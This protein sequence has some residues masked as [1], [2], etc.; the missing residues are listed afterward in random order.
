MHLQRVINWV[1]QSQMLGLQLSPAN[2]FSVQVVSQ[3][4]LALGQSNKRPIF[5]CQAIKAFKSELFG[6]WHHHFLSFLLGGRINGQLLKSS[7]KWQGK[8]VVVFV[9]IPKKAKHFF[10]SNH[11]ANSPNMNEAFNSRYLALW[12][13]LL[14]ILGGVEFVVCWWLLQVN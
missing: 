4:I 7:N 11:E 1:Q 13:L 6:V 8:M 5:K 12:I 2:W 14:F 9:F 10:H 3:S